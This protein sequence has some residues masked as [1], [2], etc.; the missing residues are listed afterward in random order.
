MVFPAALLL[1]S[2]ASAR[3]EDEAEFIAE[4]AGEAKH[5]DRLT[6]AVHLA[7]LS[8]YRDRGAS[9][10]E[11][12]PAIQGSL[13]L[14]HD[15]G[16]Y[17][18]LFA[19]SIGNQDLLGAAEID[20]YGGWAGQ[21]APGLTLDAMALYYYYPDSDEGIF[22]FTDLFETTI[23]LSGELGPFR[24]RAGIWYAWNQAALGNQDNLYLFTDLDVP[25]GTAPLTATFHV[26]YTDGGFSIAPDGTT[27]DWS[28]QLA[29]Q[30]EAGLG[31]AVKYI[32]MD[33]PRVK[34]LTDDT[35]IL[36]LS[37]EF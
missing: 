10:S 7:A 27:F 21:V 37:M 35:V 22:P 20:F 16:F 18:G 36:V 26:G 11:G 13:T 24:P 3:P 8:D 12:E 23:Q 33:G 30:S 6:I 28:A 17:A 9:Y 14:I 25:L 15:S 1:A 34:D 19:S 2:P 32:G 31:L 5:T 4:A 29:F